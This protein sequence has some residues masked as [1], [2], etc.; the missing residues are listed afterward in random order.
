[1]LRENPLLSLPRHRR[2]K[3]LTFH[4]ELT[5]QRGD[6]GGTAPTQE[7][8]RAAMQ[9]LAAGRPGDGVALPVGQVPPDNANNGIVMDCGLPPNEG[10]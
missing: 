2:G 3:G 7:R 8:G 10:A 9:L 4:P 5:V 6:G 1:L